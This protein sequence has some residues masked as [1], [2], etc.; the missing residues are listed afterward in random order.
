FLTYCYLLAF[1]A[2]L[3]L[4]PIVLCYDWQVGSIP[5]VESLWDLRNMAA[6]MLALGL[7]ALCLHCVTSLQKMEG[8]EVL[9]GILFLVFPFIPATNLFFR[10]GFVVAERVLYMP[11]K[12]LSPVYLFLKYL[13]QIMAPV[14]QF[15]G[16]LKCLGSVLCCQCDALRS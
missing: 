2:W 10:V 11:R 3:L 9:V 15:L 13:I 6:V 14:P 1:N 4:A 8:R 5:L 16:R 12:Q 7:L